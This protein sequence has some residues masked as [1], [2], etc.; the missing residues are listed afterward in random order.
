LS[1]PALFRLTL[2]LCALAIAVKLGDAPLLDADE[3]RNAEVGRE[4]ALTN[5]YVVPRLN[6]LPYLDKPI[7]YFA[8]EA[9]LMEV[10]GPT[11]LAA[12]LPAYLFTLMTAAL[13]FWFARK[14]WGV[15]SAYAAAIVFL[16]MPLTIAF[17]RIV[18]FD[19]AL[20]LFMT[21]SAIGFYE[22]V[23][24]RERR[25]ATLAWA[26]IAAGVLTKGPVAI[27][28]PLF[29]AIPYAIR[30]KAFGQLWSW[31]G[32]LAFVAIIT[33]WVWA[34]QLAVP[35][36]LQYVA[37]TE[38][39]ARLTT[40][41]LQRTGPPWY[42]VPYLIGGAL[43]WSILAIPALR[44]R[45]EN[46]LQLFL[47]LWIAVPFLFF[48]L[49]QSKRPQYIVPLM[50]PIALLV[51]SSWQ[52]LRYRTTAIAFG[53]FGA[54]LGA[55]PFVPRFGVAMKP[56]IAEPARWAAWGIGAAFVVGAL[57]AVMARRR[58]LA[59]IALALPI[60]TIPAFTTPLMHALAERRSAYEVAERVRPHL[61]AGSEVIGIRAFSGS[62]AFYLGRPVTVATDDAS[63]FTSNYIVR[64]YENFAGR[65]RVQ[66]LAWAPTQFNDPDVFITRTTDRKTRSMLTDRGMTLIAEGAR[67]AA[68]K[69][70]TVN[71]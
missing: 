16:A 14:E 1:T 3:G 45:R 13:V 44:L 39:A 10:L 5:D 71:R 21:A 8:A 41:E 2:V 65:S 47:L 22:A 32:L 31:G 27:V 24:R 53:L 60:V 15:E 7:V 51:A 29:V 58:D 61:T 20:T 66:P 6:E 49:S 54:L 4:M 52:T 48:T 50:V 70:L 63:E 28:V 46:H 9:A 62:L 23:E 11:E 57:V 26:S 35:D 56:V 64:R 25:W 67:Y 55:A 30:R 40:S 59:L 19:S 17:A 42:F 12:R 37:V 43:P 34:M 36:F 38:T 18:I 33:P 69:R 68:Y